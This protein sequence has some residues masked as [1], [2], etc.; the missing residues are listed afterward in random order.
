MSPAL[1][2]AGKVEQ[3]SLSCLTETDVQ[4]VQLLA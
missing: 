4:I 1:E 3:G 2:F